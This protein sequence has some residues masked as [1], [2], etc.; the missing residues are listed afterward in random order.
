MLPSNGKQNIVVYSI[1]RTTILVLYA[2]LYH[3]GYTLMRTYCVFDNIQPQQYNRWSLCIFAFHCS[4]KAKTNS[5]NNIVRCVNKMT[6][7]LFNNERTRVM[8]SS[9][10]ETDIFKIVLRNVQRDA[11][12][13][14]TRFLIYFEFV[15]FRNEPMAAN[16]LKLL[17]CDSSNE[18]NFECVGLTE[19][20]KDFHFQQYVYVRMNRLLPTLRFTPS[21]MCRCS[22]K[23]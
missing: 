13:L 14:M 18:F 11:L 10:Q 2:L 20:R 1:E 7:L 4:L 15:C 5:I 8:P 6:N 3:M 23:N 17:L 12:L 19:S 16:S 21:R 9:D 22:W